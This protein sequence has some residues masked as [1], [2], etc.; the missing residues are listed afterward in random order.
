MLGQAGLP[1]A[2][3]TLA[4]GAAQRAGL[5][6]ELDVGGPPHPPQAALVYGLARELIANVVRHAQAR[7]LNVVLRDDDHGALVLVVQDDG[8]GLDQGVAEMRL[9]QGH[10]GLASQRVRVESAGGTFDV[11]TPQDGGT[12][13]EARVPP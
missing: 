3:Q 11:A 8:V 4:E 2:V 10:I 13:V 1:A 12:R 6:L 7:T 9:A 5:E